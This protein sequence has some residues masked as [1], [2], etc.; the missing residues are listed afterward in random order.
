[1]KHSTPAS[2]PEEPSSSFTRTTG[3]CSQSSFDSATSVFYVYGQNPLFE[4]SRKGNYMSLNAQDDYEEPLSALDMS[5]ERLIT[6]ST[7]PTS[8]MASNQNVFWIPQSHIVDGKPPIP[9]N[10]GNARKDRSFTSKPLF[11]ENAEH[12][13]ATRNGRVALSQSHNKEYL[14]NS[15]IRDAVSLGRIS[16]I[17]PPLCS[18]CQNKTPVF[19][20]PPRQFSYKELE[21]ATDGFSDMNFL[22]EG[23]FGVVHKGVLRDGQVVAVKKLKFGGSQADADFC[24]EV[25]VLSCAQHRNVVMLIGYCIKGKM[26]LLVYEYICNSSLDFHLH[27]MLL[28]AP[29]MP[30]GL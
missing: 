14:M 27:G 23:G 9:R 2:S 1:M 7:A 6:L 29:L 5:G 28:Q 18:L 30:D 26:R 22:A 8:V 21:E 15:S 16:S 3:E 20:K 19:G 4:R 12:D 24:R 11:N 17:P 10:H 13:Q 25:R